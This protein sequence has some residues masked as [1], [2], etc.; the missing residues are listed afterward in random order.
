M[1]EDIEACIAKNDAEG[2]NPRRRALMAAIRASGLVPNGGA[3]KKMVGLTD[4]K[5]H[6]LAWEL[7]GQA[8][9][10][11][12]ASKCKDAVHQAKLPYEDKLYLDGVKDGG[13]HSALNRP[14]SFP[15]AACLKVK[16][17]TSQD[18]AA[19]LKALAGPN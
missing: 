2:R 12:V 4:P 16:I 19:L 13:R 15:Q 9:N 14:W 11:F 3:T 6:T 7:T 18:L 8:V 1:W 17:T 5:G 10:F